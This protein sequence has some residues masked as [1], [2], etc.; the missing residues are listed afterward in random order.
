VALA[1]KD[2]GSGM[3]AEVLSH[4]FEPFFTTKESGR[5]TGLGLA[6]VY[7]I[8]KQTGGHIAVESVLEGGSTFTVFLPAVAEQPVEAPGPATTALPRG[9]ATILIVEDEPSLRALAVEVL[10]DGGYRV[11]EAEDGAAALEVARV[12]QGPID[13][14]IS[15]VIMPRMGG[16]A[17][18]KQLAVD[19]PQAKV[20]F[21]SGYT[22][23]TMA[24][25][26]VLEEGVLLLLKPFTPAALLVK[27]DDVLHGRVSRRLDGESLSVA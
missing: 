27:V 13:L 25:E 5:G 1:V 8:V 12:H 21:V 7:G 18:A 9:D 24:R 23:D 4:M 10:E 6:T 20:L 16:P 15:D 11:L 19:R 22:A 26:G 3:T 2:V 14:V 17:L